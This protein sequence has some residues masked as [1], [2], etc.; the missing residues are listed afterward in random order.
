MGHLHSFATVL[1]QL[2][3]YVIGINLEKC[4]RCSKN[5]KVGNGNYCPTGYKI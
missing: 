5:E 4:L 2:K 3:A 1:L